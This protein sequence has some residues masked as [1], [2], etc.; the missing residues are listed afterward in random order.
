MDESISRYF[1]WAAGCNKA[2]QAFPGSVIDIPSLEIVK[3]PADTLRKICKFLSISC[4]ERYIQDCTATVDPV[5][6]MTRDLIEWTTEQKNRVYEE[7]KKYSFFDGYSY[8]Q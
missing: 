6:S 8:D 5:P 3:N 1:G 7:M 2:R 4:S